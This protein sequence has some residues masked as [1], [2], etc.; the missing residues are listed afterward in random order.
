MHQNI[1]FCLY[2]GII[3]SLIS[4][5]L[6]LAANDYWQQRVAYEIH[7]TLNDS[8][9]TLTAHEKLVYTNQS[10]DTLNF[11]W[12]HLWPNAYK[13]NET[14][15][16]KQIL[17]HNSKFYY[18]KEKDR[19]FIDSLD[20]TAD[21][22]SLI[23]EFH[24]EWI[25]VI[26]VQLSEPLVPG[27]SV[28][29]ETPFFVKLPEV[30][31]RLGHTGKHYEI[32][33]WYPKPAVYDRKGWHPMPY[34]D[35]GE[36]FSEFGTF[37]VFITL[38][39]NYRIMATGDLIDGETEY[40]WLDSLAREGEVLHSL[41]KKVFKK[42]I[43][44]MK[45]A[46]KKEKKAEKKESQSQI[47]SKKQ[48]MKTLHFHQE[49]VHDFAWFADKNWIV[50]K[51]TLWLLARPAE[52]GA[53]GADST[54]KVTLWSM[55]LPKNAKLW[56]NSIEYLHDSGYWYGKFYGDYPYNHIT[57]VDGDLSAGGGM[58]YPNITV[59]SKMPSQDILEFVIM[60]EV[61]H[62]WFY[63]ILG[64][65][66]RD[67][68]WM[69]EGL[70]EYTNIRY[71]EK[72]YPD[73]N[74]QII[75]VDFIQNKLG[76][77]KN[78]SMRWMDYLGYQLRA[79]SSD[80]QPIDLPA[81]DFH[82]SNYGSIVYS[83]TAIFTRFLEHYLGEEKIDIVMQDFYETWKFKHPSPDDFKSFF[84]KHVDEDLSW[85][86][87]DAIN[88][89]KVI[90]YSVSSIRGGE[91]TVTN[92]GT[93]SPPVELVFY[94]GSDVEIE[95]RWIS[96]FEGEQTV[97]VPPKTKRAIIDPDNYMPDINRENNS[98]SKSLKFNFVFDQP[99]FHSREFNLL[100]WLGWNAFNRTTLGFVGYTGF[101][102][103]FEYGYSISPQWDFEH[104]RVV[105]AILAQK[106][107]YKTLGFRRLTLSTRVSEYNGRKGAQ[108]SFSGL[109]RERIVSFP[110]INVS[111]SLFYHDIDSVAVS[112]MY[113]DDG[114]FLVLTSE[115]TYKQRVDS[116]LSYS[117]S[118]GFVAGLK[119]ASFLKSHILGN[120]KWRYH[121]KLTMNVRTWLGT[122]IGDRDIPTQYR[123]WMG[124]GVDPDFIESYIFNRMEN[125]GDGGTFVNKV[126][127][128]DEQYI[129][130]GPGLRG[131]VP[132]YSQETAWGINIDQTLPVGP[133]SLFAD[134]GGATDLLRNF[135]DVGLKISFGPVN[136]YFPLFQS[137]DKKN[138]RTIQDFDWLKAR[139][140]FDFHLSL[141]PFS[142]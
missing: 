16:A 99:T 53:G 31:S 9:H 73:R 138:E 64:S 61:G 66:E 50:R 142:G 27:G 139:A 115:V 32:T 101:I 29:I 38:P 74:G 10:P 129:L 135:V 137:W 82:R 114:T 132:N 46:W 70:N 105:G 88:D 34:L 55:Y 17:E 141:N 116:F 80:D 8:A 122:F 136:I 104:D 4:M 97:A 41:D 89:T 13:N 18:A 100:P 62:N 11:I 118:I 30:F 90:D 124:G 26:K 79:V 20:F 25:D 44:E 15:F 60:H 21:G 130:D 123:I 52:Q 7:V 109:I 36:F 28:T 2:Q 40:A 103:G 120:L 47:S 45:K 14:A 68:A 76:I 3:L 57:A 131:S 72:K 54:R 56:E 117:G 121:K 69:D 85:F 37:D 112:P 126:N 119:E 96:G 128:Y 113:Y 134:I 12:F 59:I 67:H 83:K 102:P 91:V 51:G 58:E 107:L 22:V 49:N 81:S 39:E 48:K 92:L 133:I 106:T 1:K 125:T 94:N 108:I 77:A 24:P 6:P 84:D 71:W 98:T 43:K 93:M 63:G 87:D 110:S 140:R 23:W 127:V 86:F 95:R 19:G 33:Q 111:G 5:F 42:K 65:N 35:Q 75:I 78:L